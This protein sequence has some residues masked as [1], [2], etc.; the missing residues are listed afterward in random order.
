M[1]CVGASLIQTFN[2]RAAFFGT[3]RTKNHDDQHLEMENCLGEGEGVGRRREVNCCYPENLTCQFTCLPLPPF[4]P[5]SPTT[6]EAS[7]TQMFYTAYEMFEGHRKRKS[8]WAWF[9]L[10]RAPRRDP[11]LTLCVMHALIFSSMDKVAAR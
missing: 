10:C 1:N 4:L 7:Q 3:N 9:P 8:A 6:P 11:P 2:I 5:S